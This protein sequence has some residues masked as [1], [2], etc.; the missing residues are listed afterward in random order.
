MNTYLAVFHENSVQIGDAPRLLRESPSA[1]QVVSDRLRQTFPKLVFVAPH[2]L[3]LRGT[4][5]TIDAHEAIS[6]VLDP[7]RSQH[8]I[9][10]RTYSDFLGGGESDTF[11]QFQQFFAP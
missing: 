4:P 3:L 7:A 9:L 6:Q 1:A 10:V 11:R 2:I 8:V 5:S